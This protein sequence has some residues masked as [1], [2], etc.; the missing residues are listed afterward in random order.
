MLLFTFL[1]GFQNYAKDKKEHV[2]PV[3]YNGRSSCLSR[4]QT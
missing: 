1:N 4:Y 2:Y 3:K